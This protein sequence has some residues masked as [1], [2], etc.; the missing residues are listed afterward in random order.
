MRAATIQC[1]HS[2]CWACI[3][4]WL[5][6]KQFVCPVCRTEVAL[7]PVRTRAVDMVVQKTVS[8]CSEEEQ[9]EFAA[10]LEAAEAEESRIQRHHADLER[11]ISEALKAGKSFFHVNKLW[12]KKNKAA[13][14]ISLGEATEGDV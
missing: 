4:R 7:E 5:Q 3:D 2:F 6:T 11:S 8:Q 12:G 1:S 14:L 9:K 13:K 10:R